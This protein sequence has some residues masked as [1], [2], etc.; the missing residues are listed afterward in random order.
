MNS[1]IIADLKRQYPDSWLL[2]KDVQRNAHKEAVSGVLVKIADTMES[3]E[4]YYSPS[5]NNPT[6]CIILSPESQETLFNNYFGLCTSYRERKLILKKL[7]SRY[8]T[9]LFKSFWIATCIWG[10]NYFKNS[11]SR[12]GFEFWIMNRFIPK[13]SNIDGFE[14]VLMLTGS[15]NHSVAKGHFSEL[16]RLYSATFDKESQPAAIAKIIQIPGMTFGKTDIDILTQDGTWC[17]SKVYP[18]GIGLNQAM[19]TKLQKMK[20]AQELKLEVKTTQGPIVIQSLLLANLGPITL[21]LRT[22]AENLGIAVLPN[23][24]YLRTPF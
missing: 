15:D 22:Y 14:H 21:S 9:P 7:L 2:L 3:L 16:T 6:E 10:S 17:E 11:T 12:Y 23:S 20:R 8:Q 5:G 4:T 1:N 18:K 13:L 24:I 19:K